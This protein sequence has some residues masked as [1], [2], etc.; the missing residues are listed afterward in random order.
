MIIL[1]DNL[2]RDDR[3]VRINVEKK[4]DL[5]FSSWHRRTLPRYCLVTDV[6]FLEYRINNNKIRL[7]A[8]LETKKYYVTDPKYVENNANFKA[9]KLLAEKA[10]IPFYYVLYYKT[11]M[12]MVTNR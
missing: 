6:D 1:S 7:A 12:R 11:I 2:P 3:G 9:I 10:G 4:R 8:I 5:S